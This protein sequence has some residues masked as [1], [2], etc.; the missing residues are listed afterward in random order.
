MTSS[1][2]NDER[3]ARR[4]F[5]R[6]ADELSLHRIETVIDA[7]IERRLRSYSFEWSEFSAAAFHRVVSDFVHHVCASTSAA[8]SDQD[9]VAAALSLLETCYADDAGSGYE[10][11]LRAAAADP[12]DG[13]SRVLGQL[14]DGFKRRQRQQHI[15]NTIRRHLAALSFETK[16]A[17]AKLLTLGDGPEPPSPVELG[18]RVSELPALIASELAPEDLGALILGRGPIG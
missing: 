10:C 8:R 5:A 3:A 14:V 1:I 4:A 7:P 17:L 11:A 15:N 9:S 12:E 13:I 2:E 16:L 6:L 18:R